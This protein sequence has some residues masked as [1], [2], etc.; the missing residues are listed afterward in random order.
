MTKNAHAH[1]FKVVNSKNTVRL[2][3]YQQDEGVA[4]DLSARALGSKEM[5][6]WC[7]PALTNGASLG[8]R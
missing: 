3:A 1:G 2:S 6:I 8:Y 4:G 5:Q 7:Q